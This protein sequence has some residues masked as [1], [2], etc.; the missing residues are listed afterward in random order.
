MKLQNFHVDL[1]DWSR[2]RARADITVFDRHL[3]EDEA[4]E[5]LQ[6]L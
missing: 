3:A 5:T 1:A 2:V 6:P 4:V